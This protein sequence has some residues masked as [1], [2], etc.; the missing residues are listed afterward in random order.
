[1]GEKKRFL[2]QSEDNWNKV[3]P[4][5]IKCFHSILLFRKVI[6]KKKKVSKLL[7]STFLA[8]SLYSNVCIS[9]RE[10]ERETERERQRERF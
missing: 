6:G 5:T 2:Q 8:P 7:L 3:Q 4:V 9:T 1:M 10:R